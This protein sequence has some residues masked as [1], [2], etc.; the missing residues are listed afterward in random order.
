MTTQCYDAAFRVGE[1]EAMRWRRMT[2]IAL[3]SVLAWT[4]VLGLMLAPRW[5]ELTSLATSGRD[6]T[7]ASLPATS[8]DRAKDPEP[9]TEPAVATVRASEQPLALPATPIDHATDPQ[10][11]AKPATATVRTSE[12]PDAL[13]GM[14]A[15]IATSQQPN[16]LSS[17]AAKQLVAPTDTVETAAF[18]SESS[19][20]SGKPGSSRPKAYSSIDVRTLAAARVRGEVLAGKG[21][22]VTDNAPFLAGRENDATALP[23]V[24]ADE[25][26][27]RVS[28][29]SDGPQSLSPRFDVSQSSASELEPLPGASPRALST[30]LDSRVGSSQNSNARAVLARPPSP[31]K[32]SPRT[33]TSRV[34]LAQ[35]SPSRHEVKR[36][37]PVSRSEESQ[38]PSPRPDPP[39]VVRVA[40]VD[41]ANLPA[42]S[43]ASVAQGFTRAAPSRPQ[44][45]AAAAR[46]DDSWERR[47]RWLRDRLQTR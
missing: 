4:V 33:P 26:A 11:D 3:A 45:D 38:W 15:V 24:V 1:G 46:L 14:S 13:P 2:A 41:G 40:P 47:E 22:L 5:P 25:H 36:V 43:D 37:A 16:A 28:G 44:Q 7:P 23:P 27:S 34:E 31:R 19:R 42:D 10:P 12:Q 32:A 9:E 20:D 35:T 18:G 8:L 21:A 17:G 6:Q 39:R 29:S 30:T